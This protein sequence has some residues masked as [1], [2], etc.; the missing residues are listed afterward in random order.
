MLSIQAFKCFLSIAWFRIL[1]VHCIIYSDG[2]F[3]PFSSFL[4]NVIFHNIFPFLSVYQTYPIFWQSIFFGG[5][6]LLSCLLF[7]VLLN[8]SDILTA[9][10]F[11]LENIMYNVT[12][13][14]YIQWNM[15][16]TCFPSALLHKISQT[17]LHI[18]T[19]SIL[20]QEAV[21]FLQ[22]E[23]DKTY[24]TPESYDKP[25]CKIFSGWNMFTWVKCVNVIHFWLPLEKKKKSRGC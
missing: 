16:R 10:P 17:E 4:H 1:W 18:K 21:K 6:T 5:G 9:G 24:L 13:M 22:K 14:Y 3:I 12:E 19:G 8:V 20:L 2:S 11:H 25:M 23:Q 15:A 7:P